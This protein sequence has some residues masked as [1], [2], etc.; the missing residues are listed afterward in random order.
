MTKTRTRRLP[1]FAF[2][3]QLKSTF[4]AMKDFEPS[5]IV[6]IAR[7]GPRVLDLAESTGVYHPHPNTDVI[8]DRSL[9]FLDPATVAGTRV[10]IFDDV[11]V[12]REEK[13]AM[14]AAAK[15]A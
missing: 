4:Q 14:K 7:K 12:L 15:K 8:S 9:P 5:T 2:N 6:V 1:P 13:R 10:A 11:F 3:A